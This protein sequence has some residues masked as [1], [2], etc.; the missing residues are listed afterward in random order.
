MG[1]APAE[2]ATGTREWERTSVALGAFAIACEGETVYRLHRCFSVMETVLT[3]ALIS[4]SE[5]T[6]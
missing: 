4:G 1:Q 3:K 6:P 5:Y 2:V